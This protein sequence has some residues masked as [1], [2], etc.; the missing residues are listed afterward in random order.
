METPNLTR[1]QEGEGGSNNKAMQL[2]RKIAQHH[3]LISFNSIFTSQKSWAYENFCCVLKFVPLHTVVSMVLLR[4]TFGVVLGL[5]FWC[6]VGFFFCFV[7]LVWF[8][9]FLLGFFHTWGKGS[10]SLL[11]TGMKVS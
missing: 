5:F 7:V 3:S 8:G 6:G 11:G 1:Q 10:C 9:V 4:I 2:P